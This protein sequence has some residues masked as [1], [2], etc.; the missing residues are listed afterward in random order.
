ME[1]KSVFSRFNFS[2]A[3]VHGGSDVGG[4]DGELTVT[5]HVGES[6]RKNSHKD[7]NT[8]VDV[9]DDDDDDDNDDEVVK[10]I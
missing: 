3:V 8:D 5:V 1:N 9:D 7:R 4:C 10:L 6:E 2:L